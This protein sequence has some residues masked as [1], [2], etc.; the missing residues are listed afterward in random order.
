M[1]GEKLAEFISHTQADPVLARQILQSMCLA[2]KEL[3]NYVLCDSDQCF[4][5]WVHHIQWH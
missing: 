1:E 3:L 5:F 2:G 4:F